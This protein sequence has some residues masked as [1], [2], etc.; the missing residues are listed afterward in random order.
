MKT[1]DTENMSESEY[2][3]AMESAEWEMVDWKDNPGEVLDCIHEQLVP[4]GLEV[5][6]LDC[7]DDAYH[8]K[9][10]KKQDSTERE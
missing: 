3:S 6:I 10:A 5:V 4:F 2:D 9:V 1:V 8:F 7:H